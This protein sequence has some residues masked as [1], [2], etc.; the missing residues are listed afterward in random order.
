MILV[1][2]AAGH[3]G[4]VLV[5]ELL[6]RG[7]TVRALVLPGEDRSALDGL[8]VEIVEGDVLKP[9]TLR[10]AFA[11]V[12]IVYHLAG[13]IAI[14]PG[15]ELLMRRVN[16]E[17]TRNILAA[18]LQS[19]V[20]RMVY[21]SSIHALQRPPQGVVIDESLHFDVSNPAGEYDRSKAAASLEVTKAVAEYGL[22]AVIVCPT[23]V[24]GPFD[25]R[26]SEMGELIR[27]WMANKV[28]VTVDGFF[29]FVDVRDVARG[30]ILACENGRRGATYILGG[31]R[32]SLE[33]M[34]RIVSQVTGLRASSI[35]IPMPLAIVGSWFAPIVL[36]PGAQHAAFHALCPGNRAKQFPYQHRARPARTG[37]PTPL[38]GHHPGR[39]GALVAGARAGAGPGTRPAGC[40]AMMKPGL[41]IVSGASSG[42]GAATARAL[43]A[44]G[45][46]LVLAARRAERLE[47][48]AGEI[49]TAG[50]QAEIFPVDLAD[51]G[52]REALF[53]AHP[54]ADLL[55]N[56]AGLGWYGYVEKMSWSVAAGNDRGQHGSLRAA[57]PALPARHA[58]PAP[59]A[60][61]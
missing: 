60:H 22:D 9:E 32:V 16:I 25:F 20:R 1:T 18:A 43:A 41:A 17:G 51:P 27:G 4:N 59:R 15:Q 34:W 7:K 8:P 38:A 52:G 26:Q 48:L 58:R 21:T 14:L 47:Q 23:G 2:G 46:R 35:K 61:H 36:P 49:N 31:E 54:Q 19:G 45:W 30:H 11:G 55:V 42:I 6:E 37:V 44:H 3:V 10:A 56:N 13:I 33:W 5:R 39:H 29:D 57:L 40:A 28:S 24:V 50:G 12:E 53:A